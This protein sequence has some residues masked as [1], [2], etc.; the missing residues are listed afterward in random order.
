VQIL[1]LVDHAPTLLAAFHALAPMDTVEMG[2]H[3]Q[4]RVS[5]LS[6]PGA[7]FLQSF[8]IL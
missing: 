7:P 5:T 8:A 2:S 1:A 6:V 4:V 3:V